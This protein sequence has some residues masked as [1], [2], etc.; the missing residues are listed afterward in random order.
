LVGTDTYAQVSLADINTGW[1]FFEF[2]IPRMG[3]RADV[4]LVV[5]GVIFVIEFKIGADNFRS[6]GA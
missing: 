4:V 6:R 2:S 5:A 1:V 3:K